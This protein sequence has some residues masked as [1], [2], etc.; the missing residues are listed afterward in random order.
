MMSFVSMDAQDSSYRL[1]SIV[2]QEG[3]YTKYVYDY[4]ENGRIKTSIGYCNEN[5]PNPYDKHE[6]FY[7]DNGLPEM[8]VAYRMDSNSQWQEKF[9]TEYSYDSAGKITEVSQF[10]K[11]QNGWSLFCRKERGYSPDGVLIAESVE[12]YKDAQ[13]ISGT[14][15]SFE[16]EGGN[17]VRATLY[18]KEGSELQN[19]SKDEYVYDEKGR[20]IEHVKYNY[21]DGKWNIHF[22][23]KM[24]YGSDGM[25]NMAEYH[26]PSDNGNYGNKILILRDAGGNV[27]A[28]QQYSISHPSVF[29]EQTSYVYDLNSSA[30]LLQCIGLDE[31][32]CSAMFFPIDKIKENKP[33]IIHESRITSEGVSIVDNRYYYTRIER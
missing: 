17:L 22:A 14:L 9:K 4:D 27:L 24:C 13:R 18:S 2:I 10:C 16:H 31:S 12:N 11:E 5:M 1:D 20:N 21:E 15:L 29:T 3:V 30:Q 25:M 23:E 6:C 26:I 33:L 8:V 32:V 19:E 7:G 28:K